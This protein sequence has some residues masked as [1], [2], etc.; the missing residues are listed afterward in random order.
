MNLNA[1]LD[2]AFEEDLGPGDLATESTIDPF[3]VGRAEL[4][5]KQDM[6][7]CGHEVA[8]KVLSKSATLYGGAVKYEILVPDGTRV[9]SGTILAKVSGSMRGILVGERISLNLLM[10]MCGI[11]T[12]TATYVDGLG[13][14]ITLRVA[15]TRKTTPLW[16]SL[17]KYAVTCGG[18]RNHR[19]G[20][21][22]ACMLKDNHITAVGSLPKAVAK[23]R[24]KNHHLVRIQVECSDLE[25]V[26]EAVTTDVD[27]VLLDNMDNETMAKAIA[28]IRE[29]RPRMVI[30]A[31]GNITPERIPSLA[32]LGLDVVSAGGLIHQARW[33]DLSLK[34][35]R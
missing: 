8:E 16:R 15:D 33:V 14:N 6:I 25:Q 29:T 34:V 5:A 7:V 12:W 21:Y 10:R 18:G 23:A 26:A 20:L 30:E 24:E 28:T 19:M 3:A 13:D 4:L 31:S 11:A 35:R 2:A 32:K 9:K 27:A 22:D 17:E 1:L